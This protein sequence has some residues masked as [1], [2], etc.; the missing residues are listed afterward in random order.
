MLEHKCPSCG[1]SIG[2]EGLCW[3]CRAEEE[4]REAQA[5]TAEQIAEK[6]RRIIQNIEALDDWDS[7]ERKN[8]WKLLSYHGAVTPEMQRAAL[9]ASVGLEQGYWRAPSDV[10]AGLAKALMAS[11]SSDEAA[12]LM[13]CLAMQGG[14]EALAALLEMERIP[15][16]WRNKLYVSPSIYAECVGWTFV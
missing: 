10:G 15:R 6:Q 7:E 12:G 8:L 9:A 14:D 16:A 5:W 1:R 4:R 2:Y 3:L 13:C 11:D